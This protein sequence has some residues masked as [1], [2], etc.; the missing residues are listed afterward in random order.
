VSNVAVPAAPDE[1]TP[2]NW[3]TNGFVVVDESSVRQPPVLTCLKSIPGEPAAFSIE[4]WS[5][6]PEELTKL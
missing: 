3:M 6:P 5:M 4:N 1:L 2:I